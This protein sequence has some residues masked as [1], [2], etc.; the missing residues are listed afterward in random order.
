M[1]HAERRV[2]LWST[3]EGKLLTSLEECFQPAEDLAPA[4]AG[5]VRF[6]LAP[7]DGCPHRRTGHVMSYG[8]FRDTAAH[9]HEVIGNSGKRLGRHLGSHRH[10]PGLDQLARWIDLDHLAIADDVRTA[11][12]LHALVRV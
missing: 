10:P 7:H 2:L 4:A 5:P 12:C 1:S 8:E 6:A 9:R 11:Q 3:L